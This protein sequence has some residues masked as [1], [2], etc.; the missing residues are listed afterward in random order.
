MKSLKQT[1]TAT[2]VF[3]ATA[4][5][6]PAA[7]L[8]NSLSLSGSQQLDTR[9]SDV[10]NSNPGL[11]A[12]TGFD[13]GGSLT[14]NSPGYSAG[15]GFY[16]FTGDYGATVT[17]TSIFDVQHV[18]LQMEA[19]P[20]DSYAWPFNGGPTLS[21][22]TGSGTEQVTLYNYL[23]GNSEVRNAGFAGEITY[24]GFLWQWDLSGYGD[25]ITD[26][27]LQIP[28]SIHTSITAVQIDASDSFAAVVPEPSAYATAL[29]LAL[30]GFTALRRRR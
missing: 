4:N 1:L 5:V 25:T 6:L 13:D 2:A 21:V 15:F 9:W 27:T 22:T 20:N 16:S 14:V 30:L 23:V 19:S 26:I 29:A 7:L 10:S 11:A 17:Q 24:S 12:D 18:V 28:V 3:L 8:L